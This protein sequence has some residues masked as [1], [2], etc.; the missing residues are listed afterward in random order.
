MDFET[1]PGI[2]IRPLRTVDD[3]YAAATVIAEVRDGDRSTMPPT[4]LRALAHSGNYAMGLWASDRLIGASVAFFAQPE[5]R[6]MHSQITA[7]LPEFQSHGLGRVLKRHQR[8]WAL[9]R[10][11]GHITWTFDPLVARNAH[12]YLVVLGARATEYLVNQYGSMDD[13][14]GGADPSDRIMVSWALAAPPVPP[15]PADRVE[16]CVRVPGDIAALRR[17]DAAEAARWRTDVRAAIVAH[18]ESGLIIGGFDDRGYLFVRP[19]DHS[20]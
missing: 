13:G 20:R 11:V 2:D 10:D 1:P 19:L 5:D 16:A 4:L 17:S 14:A 8:E 9:N 7:V 18:L 3:V 12:F 15:P 6:S